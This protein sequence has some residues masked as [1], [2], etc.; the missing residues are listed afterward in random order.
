MINNIREFFK[1]RS[2]ASAVEYGLL[3]GLVAVTLS[4][5]AGMLGTS[6]SSAL[7]KPLDALSSAP[8]G[9]ATPAL[10]GDVPGKAAPAAL[11]VPALPGKNGPGKAAPVA[12]ADPV[13]S[14]A[15]SV[16]RQ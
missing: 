16:S 1:N 11:A 5:G 12:A 7:A 15:P 14:I 13:A 10:G 8:S 4:V 6:I 2:G 9:A 3:V